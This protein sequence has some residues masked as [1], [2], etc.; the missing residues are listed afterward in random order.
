MKIAVLTSGGDSAGMNAAVR[1][2]C[3]AGILQGC[4]TWVVREGYEG[5]VLGNVEMKGTSV[6]LQDHVEPNVP[7]HPD[8]YSILQ[9]LR[10]GD[11][12]LLREGDADASADDST[13]RRSLKG[14]HII[15]VGWDDV[16]GWLG[17]GGTLIGTARS[18]AFRT[19]EGRSAAAHNLIK[20]GIDALVVCGGDGSLTGADKLRAEWPSLVKVLAE[21]GRITQEQASKYGHL[22]VAGLVGSIDN[23]MALTDITIGAFTALH[24][25]CES[26]D[27][28]STTA[29]SHSRAFVVEVMG[30]H[31][32]WLALVAGM[33][34]GADF[35]FIPEKPAKVGEWE[36]EMY[37]II[38]RHR[39][40]GKRK[41][42]VI[43]AEGALD[44]QLNPIKPDHVKDVLQNRLGLDTRVTTLGHTQRGGKPCAMDRILPTLQGFEAVDALLSATPD[45]PSY[46]IGISE[47]KIT[48]VPLMEAV[49]TA[50]TQAVAKAIEAKDFE[51]A[52]SLRDPEF[53]ETYQNFLTTSSISDENLLP[54]EQRLRIAIIHVGAPA[55]GMNAATRTAVRFC[56]SR[57]HLPLAIHNGFIGL[58]NDNINELSWLRV[59]NWM[60][61]GGS[62]LGTNRS[63]PDINLGQVASQFQKH[64][65]DALFLIGGFEAFNS[66]LMLE[67]A[68]QHYPSFNIPMVHLPA[69]ISNN[70]P[71]TEFSIGSDTSL[72][73]LVDACDAIKQSASASRNRVFV[74]ETQ[75]GKCGYIATMGGLAAGAVLV[76]TPEVG[77]NLGM[78]TFD[79]KHLKNRYRLDIKGKSEGRLVLRNEKASEVYTTEVITKMF[80]EEGTSLFDSRGIPSPLDRARAA[81]LASKCMTFLETQAHMLRAQSATRR[82]PP[83]AA[84]MITIEGS[85]VRF[86]PVTRVVEHADMKDRR[87]KHSWWE[88]YRDLV[89]ELGGLSKLHVES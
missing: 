61:R 47:N 89:H 30:R 5:L 28:I 34:A 19:P 45:T 7:D 86:A 25:I 18:K 26:I 72:N 23:D 71:L 42:I 70:V 33:S 24:R 6:S 68:R 88:K 11:G 3:R 31:C 53:A 50:S 48:R 57:G 15:R 40:I 52:M 84:A 58:L 54:N 55:G 83:N 46:M 81:R 63:L 65:F 62:E 56:L 41:T 36:N 77:I 78:L 16:R 67:R 21:Q 60:T 35:I 1:A 38:T 59:D 9:N 17:E 44:T 27:N 76:Y 13:G 79:V 22:R 87:A 74:V 80:R 69:T 75:G 12:E 37:E 29:S 32:G 20:E 82:A 14:R 39:K 85:S 64:Q 2:V 66:L 49:K 8:H 73:A 4:E 51:K 43:I 10:F